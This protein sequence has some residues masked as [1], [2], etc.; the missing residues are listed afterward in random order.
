MRNIISGV[1]ADDTINA[2]DAK[3]VG[4]AKENEMVGKCVAEHSFKK[5]N[6]VVTMASNNAIKVNQEL[7]S[8]DP[9]VLFQ[10]LVTAGMSNEQLPEIFQFELSSYPLHYLTQK[11]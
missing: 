7:V 1:T 4:T 5:K 11:M 10:R 6:Q 8:I 9:Q 2:E 3:S